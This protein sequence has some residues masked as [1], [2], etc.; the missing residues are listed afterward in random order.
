MQRSNMQ[1]SIDSMKKQLKEYPMNYRE[2]E[3]LNKKISELESRV[4]SSGKRMIDKDIELP[5]TCLLLQKKK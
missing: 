3:N 4:E 5:G 1:S 2:K